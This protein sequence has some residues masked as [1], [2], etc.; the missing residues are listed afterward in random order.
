MTL[1]SI[2]GNPSGSPGNLGTPLLINTPAPASYAAGAS[3]TL[4][5][6]DVLGGIVV[7]GGNA[8][9]AS[10]VTLPTAA[11]LAAAMRTASNLAAVA[12]GN[13]VSFSLVNGA[14]T[15]A[16]GV[17]TVTPGSG[18]ALDANQANSTVTTGMSKT[19]YIRFTNGTLNSEAYVVYC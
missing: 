6:D 2:L 3:Q 13:T 18:G 15:G 10:T 9:S 19:V 4:T 7:F 5:A 12:V 1:A 14:A 8:N 11:L 17:I 16:T